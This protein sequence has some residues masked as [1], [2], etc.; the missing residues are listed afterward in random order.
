VLPPGADPHSFELTPTAARSVEQADA[1]FLVGG[2]F[3]RWILGNRPEGSSRIVEIAAALGDS[4]IKTDDEVN[5][6]IWLDPLLAKDI[7]RVIGLELARIDAANRQYYEARVAAFGAAMDSLNA[8]VK[9]RLRKCGFKAYVAAH[10]AW[11]YF[12]RR[13]GIREAAV[14]ELTPEQEPSA[15]WIARVLR[16]MKESDVRVVI[17]EEFSNLALANSIAR[18]SGA[19]VVVLDPIGGPT[20]PG[21]DSYAALINYNLALIEEAAGRAR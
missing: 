18:D 1:I 13:Y 20:R 7:G 3:D 11:T 19:R 8:A 16:T 15:R 5:P 14:L 4:L 12:A 6:H 9:A 17:A 2:H 21:R 10:P